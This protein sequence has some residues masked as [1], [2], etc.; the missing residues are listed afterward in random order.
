MLHLESGEPV[1]P[2]DAFN[3]LGFAVTLALLLTLVGCAGTLSGAASCTTDAHCAA[4]FGGE[5]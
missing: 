1:T 5:Y 2:R 4:T 3:A